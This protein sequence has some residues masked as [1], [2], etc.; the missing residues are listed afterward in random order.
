MKTKAST[1]LAFIVPFILVSCYPPKPFAPLPPLDGE[2]APKVDP[3]A[4]ID[5]QHKKELEK[6]QR[7]NQ[8]IPSVLKPTNNQQVKETVKNILPSPLTPSRSD[9]IDTITPTS[10]IESSIIP[11][12]I[13]KKSFPYA[14]AV[15]GK[16]GFVYNP[17]TNT[18]IDVRGF[19]SGTLV[20]APGDAT[21]KFY[22]P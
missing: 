21:Q 19:A 9:T 4:G 3:N 17:Y 18:K 13:K 1:L 20:S 16:P 10:P 5:Q 8:T 12:P 22:V 2:T 15:D 6:F 7:E 14:K 11:T